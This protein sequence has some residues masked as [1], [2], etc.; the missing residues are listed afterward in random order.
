MQNF[1]RDT[2]GRMTKAQQATYRYARRMP[3]KVFKEKDDPKKMHAQHMAGEMIKICRNCKA[4]LYEK[5]VN[6]QTGC[7]SICCGNGK[8]HLTPYPEPPEPLYS[9]FSGK[10]KSLTEEFLSHIRR[11]NHAFTMSSLEANVIKPP[12]RGLGNFKVQGRTAHR[13]TAFMVDTRERPKPRRYLQIFLP[14]LHDELELRMSETQQKLEKKILKDIQEMLH[15]ENQFVKQFKTLYELH[16]HEQVKIVVHASKYR[17]QGTHSRSYNRAQVQECAAIMLEGDEPI[18]KQDM[19]LHMRR[20]A[21]SDHEVHRVRATSKAYD[22]LFYVLLMP[23]GED[24][25]DLYLN[26]PEEGD[27]KITFLTFYRFHLHERHGSINHLMHARMLTQQ[28]AT[29]I[30]IRYFNVFYIF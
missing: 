18:S 19:I 23:R 28:W 1:L 9:L 22:P 30:F 24:G 7:G 26:S 13:V 4:F 17:P 5:E 20:P 3:T 16:N 11:Y 27:E 15:R 21:D 14:G 25:Y 2:K 29:E 12:S 10:D 8:I 6:K